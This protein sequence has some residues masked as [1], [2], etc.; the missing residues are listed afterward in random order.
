MTRF[1]HDQFAK[2]YLRELLSSLG[3]V[4]SSKDIHPES[5]QIDLL[6]TPSPSGTEERENLGLL[7]KLTVTPA[8]LDARSLGE[9]TSPGSHRY[10]NPSATPSPRAKFAL[11][12][13]NCL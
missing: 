5:R 10:L 7:G 12:S 4:E 13:L 8:C 2:Q 3:R 6:F 9:E 1:I 11:V